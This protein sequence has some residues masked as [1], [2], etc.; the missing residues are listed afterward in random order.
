M[1]SESILSG[2]MDKRL[3]I[4]MV[5]HLAQAQGLEA[6]AGHQSVERGR[7][8]VLVGG[9]CVRPVGPGEGNPVAAQDGRPTALS[10]WGV[11]GYLG[12]ML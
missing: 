8:H 10:H 11:V 6:E 5:V 9:S 7:E 12:S 3:P 2:R 1:A 4:A